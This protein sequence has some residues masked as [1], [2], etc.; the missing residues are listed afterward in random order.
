VSL[1]EIQEQFGSKVKELEKELALVEQKWRF[2]KEENQ[3]IQRQLVERSQAHDSILKA[4]EDKS[5]EHASGKETALQKLAT[6]TS[7]H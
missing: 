4:L 6:L 3:T 2:G 7:E 1:T 5:S